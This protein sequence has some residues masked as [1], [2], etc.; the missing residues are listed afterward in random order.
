LTQRVHPKLATVRTSLGPD[1][2]ELTC[3]MV[4]RSRLPLDD[5][6]TPR[7]VEVWGDRVVAVEPDP[8]ASAAI[9]RWLGRAVALVRFPETATR[10]CDPAYAPAGSETAFADGFP[11]LVTTTG[12]L[13]VLNEAIGRRGGAPCR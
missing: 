11:L 5:R 8:R 7:T 2:L 6:G 1:A 10:P 9:G 12:S 13:D 4:L 3:R